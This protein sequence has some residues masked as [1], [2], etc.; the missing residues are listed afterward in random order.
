MLFDK[1]EG[2]C[3]EK[4]FRNKLK[5]KYSDDILITSARGKKSV[6][7]F[8]NTGYTILTS[9]CYDSKKEIRKKND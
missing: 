4:T 1:M 6:F 8:R 7:C 9:A 5:E 2:L 3:E